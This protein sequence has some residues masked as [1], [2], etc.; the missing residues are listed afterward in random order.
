MLKAV[1][2][3]YRGA[4]SLMSPLTLVRDFVVGK[5]VSKILGKVVP[6]L[7]GKI[8]SK[9]TQEQRTF[10]VTLKLPNK[11]HQAMTQNTES[12]SFVTEV[13]ND[14]LAAPLA[15]IG[16]S[17]GKLAANLEEE[18]LRVVLEVGLLAPSVEVASN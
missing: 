7:E 3:T 6:L 18:G 17:I 5:V 10:S 15:G 2:A 8:H 11:I 14:A 9:L 16:Y 12:I 13:L 1:I 4:K